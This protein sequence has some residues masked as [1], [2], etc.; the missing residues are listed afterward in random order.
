MANLTFLETQT[1]EDFLDMGGGYVLNFSDRTFQQFIGSTIGLNIDDPK[2]RA[3][4][5]SKAKRLRGFINEESEYTI[6]KL[7][8]ALYEYKLHQN[9]LYSGLSNPALELAFHKVTERLLSEKVIQDIDA[10][11][12]INDDKDFHQLA[13]LIRESIEKN[14]P[15]AALDR[16]HT[17]L[18]K[19]LKELCSSHE[20]IF[21]KEE[22]VNALFGKYIKAIKAKDFLSSSMSEK[23]IQFSF[24]IMDAFNDIRN[25]KSFAHDNPVLNYDESILIFSNITATVKFIQTLETKNKNSTVADAIPDWGQF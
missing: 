5:S 8:K 12:A 10:I 6:G 16:L 2:Y 15:E 24:Q 17:F 7:F 18:V 25:N 14:E 19:F 23:I 3:Y 11:Q 1:V 22:T 20:I 9:Q 21:N 13:R 4:G